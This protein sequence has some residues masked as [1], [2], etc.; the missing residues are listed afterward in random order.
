M[1]IVLS[2]HEAEILY[3]VAKPAAQR[4]RERD[5]SSARNLA[6][7]VGLL[8]EDKPL[9]PEVYDSAI[10]ALRDAADDTD[11]LAFHNACQAL[12]VRLMAEEQRT[13]QR[14]LLAPPRG[15]A[16]AAKARPPRRQ[17]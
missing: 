10:Y 15:A 9:S 16:P 7:I 4:A 13:E 12:V 2:K 1:P 6:E 14:H 8:R 17:K 5:F 3:K 11:D